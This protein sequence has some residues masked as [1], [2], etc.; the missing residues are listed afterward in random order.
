MVRLVSANDVSVAASVAADDFIKS[1]I[2]TVRGV[3]VMLDRD[4]TVLYGV[5]VKRLNHQVNRNLERFP[6]RFMHQMTARGFEDLKL[7]LQV[8]EAFASHQVFLR[9]RAH[10]CSHPYDIRRRPLKS[11]YA[12]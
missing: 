12:S 3:H 11:A 7:Q 4:W 2:F 6:G 9:S 10:P 8:G 1:R 5:E